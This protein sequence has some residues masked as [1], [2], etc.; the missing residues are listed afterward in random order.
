MVYDNEHRHV[1]IGFNH[2]KEKAEAG[3]CVNMP[4]TRS[5]L[6][7]AI[8]AQKGLPLKVSI[9]VLFVITEAITT[10]LAAGEDVKIRNFGRLTRVIVKTPQGG[11]ARVRFTPSRKLRTLLLEEDLLLQGTLGLDA[12]AQ[13]IQASMRLSEELQ[14]IV[15][16]HCLWVDSKHCQGKSADLSGLDL[17]GVDLYGSMLKGANLSRALLL[18][19]DL[20]DCD[21]EQANLEQ[22]NLTGASLA[23][24]NLQYSNLKGAC[25]KETDMQMADMTGAN[26]TGA[27][28]TG[29]NLRG[30]VLTGA[31]RDSAKSKTPRREGSPQKINGPKFSLTRW[32]VKRILALNY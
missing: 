32:L 15:E 13:Q 22:A 29:A 2:I 26:L 16:A 23:W 21:L 10:A 19:A 3:N 14:Q 18:K 20:S 6:A 5:Q 12:L 1:W 17:Q 31:T 25:L 8:S 11:H 9:R 7:R 28:L 30:I 4:L 24:A 27:D